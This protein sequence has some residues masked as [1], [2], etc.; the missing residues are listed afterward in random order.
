MKKLV[1]LSILIAGLSFGFKSK[2]KIQDYIEIQ[3]DRPHQSTVKALFIVKQPVSFETIKYHIPDSVLSEEHIRMFWE[4]FFDTKK[5]DSKTFAKIVDFVADNKF[6][7]T[8]KAGSD[9]SVTINRH[10]YR[11][12]V[13]LQKVFFS[14]LIKY[15]KME[16]CDPSII[17][18]ITSFS[19]RLV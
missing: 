19:D 4:A 5:T 10:R 1:F 9:F 15:L 17:E 6:F 16:K 2:L 12:S 13:K 14:K 18:E 7:F 3:D 11:I 8:N